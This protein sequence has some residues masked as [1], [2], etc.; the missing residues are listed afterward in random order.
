MG[1]LIKQY[2]LD[3]L[4]FEPIEIPILNLYVNERMDVK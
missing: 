3:R 2:M 4:F 1:Q